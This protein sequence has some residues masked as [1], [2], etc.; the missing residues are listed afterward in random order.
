MQKL[1]I[2]Q[3]GSSSGVILNKEILTL[4]HVQKG[5]H[6]FLT[7]AP[8]GA[9]RLTPYDPEI[10]NQMEHA[11]EAMRRDRDLLRAFSK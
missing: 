8:D 1:K 6:L 11:E 10:E 5:D 9:F 7:E 4:L 3:V 2:I